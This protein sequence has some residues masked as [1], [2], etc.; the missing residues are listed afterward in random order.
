MTGTG[1][2]SATLNPVLVTTV[3]GAIA[4]MDTAGTIQDPSIDLPLA[5]P[6]IIEAPVYTATAETFPT[7]DLL[8]TIISPEM[9]ADLDIAPD[10]ANTG[11]PK[12]HHQQHRHH[13][14]NMKTRNKNINKSSLMIHHQNITVQMKVKVTWRII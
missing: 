3:V 11:Q 10:N 9:T 8:L 1:P 6:Y 13:L 5:A 12:D 2:D 14:R 4:D 7:A